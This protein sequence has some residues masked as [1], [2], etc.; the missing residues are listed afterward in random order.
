MI[1]KG[2]LK[3]VLVTACFALVAAACQSDDGGTGDGDGDG[4]QGGLIVAF[5]PT[6]TNTYIAEWARGAK[7]AAA[8]LGY[9]L[10]IIE[11]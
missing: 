2:R 11:N 9:E 8:E 4:Q 10:K 1:G 6:T 5:I 3:W 7:D